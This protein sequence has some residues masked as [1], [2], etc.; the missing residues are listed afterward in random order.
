MAQSALTAIAEAAA[1][2]I[3]S[4]GLTCTPQ[5]FL[6]EL[7]SYLGSCSPPPACAPSLLVLMGA[8]CPS[9]ALGA[10]S[11]F[12]ERWYPLGCRRIVITGGIGRSTLGLFARLSGTLQPDAA[13]GRVALPATHSVGGPASLPV[14][15]DM[16]GFS[17]SW[18]PHAVAAYCGEA[19]VYAELVLQ[20]LLQRGIPVHY[21]RAA[22]AEDGAVSVSADWNHV[23]PDAV[24][25]ILEPGSTHSGNN[26]EY[27][28]QALRACSCSVDATLIATAVVAQQ[29]ALLARAGSTFAKWTKA[30][31]QLW[32]TASYMPADDPDWQRAKMLSMCLGE[33]RRFPTYAGELGFVDPP[34]DFPWHYSTFALLPDV[35][36]ACTALD[37]A[38]A[39][40]V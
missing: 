23:P 20:A 31:P 11:M 27:T 12:I 19:D 9:L 7:V 39:A 21:C 10:A 40:R 6:D 38:V 24:L 32:T 18:P 14:L 35:V 30:R 36:A 28:L 17:L 26:V 16:S 25:V 5:R 3:A 8:D 33:Y 34:G 4:Q 22:Y 37:A 29:P 1:G 15:A 13:T 2:F